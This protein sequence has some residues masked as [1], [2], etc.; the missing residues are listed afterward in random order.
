M[1]AAPSPSS[2]DF[3]DV[4]AFRSLARTKLLPA[5]GVCGPS[6]ANPSGAGPS[7]FDL[8]PDA[9][10]LAE[11]AS[12]AAAVLVPVL[13]RPELTLLLTERARHL[14]KH[15]GQIAFPG[16]RIESMDATAL[17]AALREAWEEVGLPPTH[18]EPLG[19]VEPYQTGTGFLVT[20]VVALVDPSFAVRPEPHEVQ[21]VFEVPLA[22]LMN[23]DNHRIDTREWRGEERRYFAMPYGERY[24]WGATAGIIRALHR[25]LF[26]T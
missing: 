11:A 10:S 14:T 13:R 4:Q 22:F 8:N 25:R 21:S 15:A 7:D 3:S 17:D 18:A 1:A 24:I 5:P 16:G 23:A 26:L 19:F 12:I 9:A 2:F 6:D 20:P